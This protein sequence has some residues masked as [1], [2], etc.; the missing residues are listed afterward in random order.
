MNRYE[1]KFER[2]GTERRFVRVAE[3]ATEAAEK[4]CNQYG[5]EW[6]Y[7]LV[8]ADTRGIES[9]ELPVAFGEDGFNSAIYDEFSRLYIDKMS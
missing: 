1:I 2:N 4:L 6:K 8:D 9:A 5:W 7:G 3:S